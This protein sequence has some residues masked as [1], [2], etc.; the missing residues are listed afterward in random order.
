MLIC[1]VTLLSIAVAS[2]PSALT[3]CHSGRMSNIGA[4]EDLKN[5]P[6]AIISGTDVKRY[7]QNLDVNIVQEG[8]LPEAFHALNNGEAVAIIADKM[9]VSSYLKQNKVSKINITDIVIRSNILSFALRKDSKLR[10][11]INDSIVHLQNSDWLYRMCLHYL[12][13][14]EAAFCTL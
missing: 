4:L 6:V 1:S 11:S 10:N 2:I 3:L 12:S 7:L 13:R 8:S 9:W 5:Q 14:R